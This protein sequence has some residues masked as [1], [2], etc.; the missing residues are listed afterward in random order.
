MVQNPNYATIVDPNGIF[1]ID[2]LAPLKSFI[3]YLASSIFNIAKTLFTIVNENVVKPIVQGFNWVLN[4]IVNGVSDFISKVIE[5]FK[6]LFYP[7]DPDRVASNFPKIYL[8][9]GLSGLTIG[10]ILSVI[11]T[12]VGGTGIEIEPLAKMVSNLFNPNLI[13]GIGIGTIVGMSLKVPLGYWAKKTFRPFKPDPITLFG[14]YTRGYITRDQLKNELAYVLGYPDIYIDG[15]IDILEFNPT[16]TQLIRLSDFV[17]I[18]DDILTKS[19]KIMGIKEPYLSL[20]WKM[21]KKR[22]LREETRLNTNLLINAY[23]KGYISREFLEKALDGL[24]IQSMEKQLL[25]TYAENKRTFEIIEERIYLLRTA[26]QKGLI[27]KATLINELNKL[28]L[29]IE[30]VNLIV[31]RGD[32][33]RKIEVPVPKITRAYSVPI[34]ISTSYEYKLS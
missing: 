14:L 6:N 32:L 19:L 34:T 18:P 7:P 25:L 33:F 26:Y 31:M 2:L 17:E 1:Q 10:T 3:D 5:T 22:P 12:K 4:L 28:G 23:S 21:I 29:Q 11:G 8:A 27:D 13:I 15:L 30:W 24:G 16:L 9:I 20:L